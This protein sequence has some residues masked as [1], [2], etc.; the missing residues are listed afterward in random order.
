MD[1]AAHPLPSHRTHT[2]SARQLDELHALDPLPLTGDVRRPGLVAGVEQG[3]PAYAVARTSVISRAMRPPMECPTSI[4]SPGACSRTASAI[5]GRESIVP[6]SA[7]EQTA[8]SCNA[9]S[10][11][12][13]AARSQSSPGRKT[14]AISNCHSSSGR[15]RRT[16]PPRGAQSTFA[17]V[18]EGS[19]AS[20]RR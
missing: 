10:W 8:R 17:L 11:D 1:H 4:N 9:I 15:L 19:E 7:T 6:Y 3:K 13:Q 14:T 2:A 20:A 5:A 16:C 18:M 12:V